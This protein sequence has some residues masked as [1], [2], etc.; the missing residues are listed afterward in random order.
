MQ[1]R[2]DL[3]TSPAADDS[4]VPFYQADLYANL[5]GEDSIIGRALVMFNVGADGLA[6][7]DDDTAGE[8]CVI[9]VDKKPDLDHHDHTSYPYPHYRPQP[10][11][12]QEVST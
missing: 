3:V 11:Y 10:Q 9:V 6:G 7:T 5:A 8:C 2:I 12:H 1:G 4:D